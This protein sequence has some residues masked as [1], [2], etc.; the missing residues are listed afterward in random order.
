MKIGLGRQRR[1]SFFLYGVIYI[2]TTK[3]S[4][5]NQHTALVVGTTVV[6][7]AIYS[8]VLAVVYFICRSTKKTEKGEEHR[9]KPGPGLHILGWAGAIVAAGLGAWIGEEISIQ[10][11]KSSAASFIAPVAM[12]RRRRRHARFNDENANQPAMLGAIGPQSSGEALGNFQNAWNQAPASDFINF[13]PKICVKK[14][15][16]DPDANGSLFAEPDQDICFDMNA[17]SYD[18][19]NKPE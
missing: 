12:M 18:Q 19:F 11:A 13:E 1:S 15:S 9:C 10:R 14:Q 2:F 7:E 6:V 3:M 4:L 17:E 5:V 8:V 16:Q